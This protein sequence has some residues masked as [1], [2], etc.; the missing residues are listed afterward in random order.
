MVR[1]RGRN[2][3][4]PNPDQKCTAD[5]ENH[6][7]HVPD[8]L[9]QPAQGQGEAGQHRTLFTKIYETIAHILHHSPQLEHPF[10]DQRTGLERERRVGCIV[11][12]GDK[13]LAGAT[14]TTC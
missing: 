4:D 12:S 6:Q 7:R 10:F 13:G 5:A 11:V 8:L 1:R 3:G 2:E 14:A 9:G